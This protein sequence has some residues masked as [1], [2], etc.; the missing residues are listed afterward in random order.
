MMSLAIGVNLLPV[1]LTTLANDLGADGAKLSGEQ[2]GRIG[3]FT[4][5]GLVIGIFIAGPLADR[6]GGKIF[7]VGGNALLAAGLWMLG[8]THSYDVLLL[9]AF[10]MG[11]GAGALDMI[12]SPIV[13]ALEPHRRTVAM[14]L[15]HSFY[16]TGAVATILAGA[17]ALR[18]GVE[19]RSV[20]FGL[21][22]MPL[23]IGLSFV[24]MP[25][26]PLV[27]EDHERMK[28]GTLMRQP[29]FLV[30]MVAIFLGGSTEL[31]MAYWL[32]AYAEK[33]LEFSK[34]TAD[35]SFLGFSLAMAVGRLGILLLPRSV[36][37][38]PLML[39]C[40]T[41]SVI[42]FPLASFAPWNTVALACC[43][44]AGLAGSCLWPSTLAVT[45]DRFPHGGATMFALLAALGN[46][47]G[48][49][50]PWIAGFVADRSSLRWGIATATLCPLLMIDTLLWMHR[51]PSPPRGRGSG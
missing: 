15:L 42:L 23:L 9:S 32:S 27:H 17:V 4:F 43:I 30:A 22:P 13:A 14:N 25:L 47:G 26:P 49:S 40:C 48:I 44:L 41:A 5:A 34:W 46:F 38:I 51:H 1:F 7:A 36:G 45:A 20:A 11:M 29:F 39:A 8:L 18:W 24:F 16:C 21:M 3:A 33:T 31:G 12:L 10:I 28:L 50:M 37:P 35:M 6:F 19:W 2:L